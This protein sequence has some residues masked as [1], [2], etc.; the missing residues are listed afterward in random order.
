MS[1][2]LP[3]RTAL[4]TTVVLISACHHA[5]P[6]KPAPRPAIVA[7]PIPAD[8]LLNSYSGEV[9]ARFQPQLSFRVSGK[10]I[11]RLVDVGDTVKQGQILAQLDPQDAELQLNA[12]KAQLASA[13]SA[14]RIA[15]AEL[16]RYKLLLAPNAI[17]RSQYDQVDNQFKA[18]ESALTQAKSQLSLANNQIEYTFLRAPQNGKIV[19]RQIEAGQVVTAGQTAYTLATQGDREVLIGIPEQDATHF[20][21]GQAVTVTVW[22]Q[23]D[24]HFP[25]HVREISPAA[26]TSRTFATRI[27][28][29]QS[30]PNVDIGQSARVFTNDAASKPLI[31]LPLSAITAEQGVAYVWVVNLETSRI[32]KMPIQVGVYGRNTATIIS[33]LQPTDWVVTAGVQLLHDDQQ[34]LPVDRQN[35]AI[36]VISPSKNPSKDSGTASHSPKQ[37]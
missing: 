4:M 2:Q 14:E 18:A 5:E 32:K 7:Q 26:D 33:G 29:D 37:G 16:A 28:F 17:S 13:E 1:M 31:S 21:V 24:A 12:A 30:E 27:A 15:S 36:D 19:Q 22:S 6:E 35:R 20:H 23:P 11:K 3:I 9:T 34:I 10:V 8:T 25:A